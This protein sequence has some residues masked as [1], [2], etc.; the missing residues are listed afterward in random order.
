[1]I[2]SYPT[3]R[4]VDVLLRDGSTVRVRPIRAEDKGA[5]IDFYRGLS[6]ESLAFRFFS[7]SADLESLSNLAIDVDYSGR[8]GLVAIR[9]S[10]GRVVAHASY[11][12]IQGA[13][14]EIAFAVADELQG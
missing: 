14:A 5:I 4:Q 1:M 12:R 13:K 8:Y 10:E 7:G 11:L 9:G 2:G 6:L 3:H